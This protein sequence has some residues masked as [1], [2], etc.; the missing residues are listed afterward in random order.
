MHRYAVG[1]LY[2]PNR[3]SWPEGSTLNAA[4]DAL[5]LLLMFSAPSSKEKQGVKRGRIQLGLF[6]DQEQVLLLYQ[7]EGAVPTWSD[8]P[9]SVQRAGTSLPSRIEDGKRHLINLTL[10]N[11]DTGVVE[12][13]RVVSVS[14]QWWNTWCEMLEAQA[15]LGVSDTVYDAGLRALLAR[16]PKSELLVKEARIVETTGVI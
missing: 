10:I 15:T 13:L 11:A 9:F 6:Q 2:T 1:E 14:D 8:Q 7:I 16:F 12:A 5:E 3:T 4:E